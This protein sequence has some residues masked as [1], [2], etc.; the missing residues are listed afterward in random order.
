MRTFTTEHTVY[1]LDE[2]SPEAR[3]QAIQ[4]RRDY[5][6]EYG[7]EWLNDD[8]EYKLEELFETHGITDNGTDMA[9]SLSYNQGDGASFT[10]EIEWKAW[11]ATITR[12]NHMY[13]HWNSTSISEMTSLKTDKDA[14]QQTL[15]KLEAIIKDIGKELER[16]GYD[17]INTYLDDENI[18]ELLQDD[19]F[20]EDGR[21]L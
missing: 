9:Y 3:E 6:W 11:R 14:P 17:C 10:G 7:M 15:E 16:Y 4:D 19:E 13:Y 12:T 21:M 2:L 1:T 5:E 20:Y 8:I 18:T